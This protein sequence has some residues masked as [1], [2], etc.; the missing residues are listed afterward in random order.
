MSVRR[1]A[2]FA[3]PWVAIFLGVAGLRVTGPRDNTSRSRAVAGRR[4][5]ASLGRATGWLNS[6]PLTP[7]SLR[8][9]VV[10]I[11][12]W[13]YLHQLA[14]HPRPAPGPRSTRTGD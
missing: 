12:V 14:A 3:A 5:P 13:T 4:G 1:N 2:F 9:H 7:S 10:V 8:G 11:D 6:Q